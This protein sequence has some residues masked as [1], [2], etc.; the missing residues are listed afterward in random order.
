[1]GNFP[2]PIFEVMS[3]KFGGREKDNESRGGPEVGMGS[4]RNCECRGTYIKFVH[5]HLIDK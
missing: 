3:A 1:M 4:G 5:N 2:N